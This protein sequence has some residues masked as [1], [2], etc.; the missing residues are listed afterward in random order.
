MQCLAIYRGLCFLSKIW[1]YCMLKTALYTYAQ[2]LPF[3]R[4]ETNPLSDDEKDRISAIV[5]SLMLFSIV[6]SVGGSCDR[7]STAAASP[8]CLLT[9]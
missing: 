3:K 1:S 7:A 8:Y 5:Q 4:D 6:W 2:V 9:G